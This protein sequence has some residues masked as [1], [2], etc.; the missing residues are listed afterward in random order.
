MRRPRTTV[1]ECQ[2]AGDAAGE[3]WPR[4]YAPACTLDKSERRVHHEFMRPRPVND[5][6]FRIATRRSRLAMTQTRLVA[7]QL[8]KRTG[9]AVDLVEVTSTG[10]AQAD[11]PLREIGGKGV[12]VKEL[13]RALLDERA[14]MA[15]HSLKDVPSRLDPSL[16]L[17]AIGWRED[18]RDALISFRGRSFAQL[19]EGARVG[20]SSLRRAILLGKLRE[21][22][23]IQPMRGNVDSRIRRLD[24]G[25]YDAL[26]LA[27]AGLKRLG[28]THRVN[29]FFSV[30]QLLPAPGQ[31]MLGVE[32]LSAREDLGEL[33]SDLVPTQ[34]FFLGSLER[35]V[36]Q[37]LGG[38][39]NLPI[40]THAELE[41]D[42]VR[43]RV[44]IA[45]TCGKIE[46]S[47]DV[48]GAP[49]MALAEKA[50]RDLL[51]RGGREVMA[52]MVNH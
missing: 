5:K 11:R 33:L 1:S 23:V 46:A 21:D 20:T 36:S 7:S 10:D 47:V 29:E 4:P 43:M 42:Q 3:A 45:S 52:G 6:P 50:V 12:F 28:L 51:D 32:V 16:S 9:R 27:V 44:W 25:E 15:V 40:A 41:K 13:E 17:A 31:G 2:A 8:A 22:L 24:E 35:H 48:R 49:H 38:D 14:D 34:Q 37:L 18:P 19:P 39:C 26:V 30:D